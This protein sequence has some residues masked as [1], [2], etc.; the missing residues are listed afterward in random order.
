L[1]LT[2]AHPKRLSELVA[3]VSDGKITSRVA[4]DLLKEVVFDNVAVERIAEERGLL[5]QNSTEELVPMV[6]QIIADHA[7][8]VAEYKAGKEASLKFLVGQG[9]KLS[10]GAANPQTLETL[11]K[12]TIL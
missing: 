6:D 12:K 4:K 2:D 3:F 10:K 11:L 8:V 7:D 9:M 5:Q 1:S